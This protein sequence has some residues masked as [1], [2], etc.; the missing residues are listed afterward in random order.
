VKKICILLVLILLSSCSLT[1]AIGEPQQIIKNVA[2]TGV[3]YAVGGWIPASAV[4]VTA[5]T[6]DK[7][8]PEPNPQIQDIQTEEQMKAFIIANLTDNILYGALAALL[9]FLVVVPWATQRRAK[10]QMK[11]DMMKRELEA[12]RIKDAN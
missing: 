3:T 6:V 4:A 11:Y 1:K 10:R 5:I 2:L 7:V 8:L 9:I 12:R